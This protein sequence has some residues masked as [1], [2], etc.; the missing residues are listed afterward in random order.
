MKKE[1]FSTHARNFSGTSQE[2]EEAKLK[3][4]KFQQK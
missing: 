1:I 2:E 3:K 4:N